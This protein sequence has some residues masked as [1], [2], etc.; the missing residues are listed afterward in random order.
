MLAFSL[1]FSTIIILTICSTGQLFANPVTITG[2]GFC[3]IGLAVLPFLVR[4]KKAVKN[5]NNFKEV[6]ELSKE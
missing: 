5:V 6:M 4:S 3:L 1:P 2:L